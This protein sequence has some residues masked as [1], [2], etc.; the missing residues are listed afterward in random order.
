MSQEWDCCVCACFWSGAASALIL[1]QLE[2]EEV[3][4]MI[5]MIIMAGITRWLSAIVQIMSFVYWMVPT[6]L[7]II[8]ALFSAVKFGDKGRFAS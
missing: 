5:I 6:Q 8:F 1:A 2:P 4:I 3:I 7:S